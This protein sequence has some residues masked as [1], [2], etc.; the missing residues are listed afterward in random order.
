[1]KPLTPKPQYSLAELTQD[2]GVT[3]AGD[4][5]RLI[6]GVATIQD[7]QPGDIAFLMN[8]LY[9]KHLQKT[10]ASAV[11]LTESDAVDCP[12]TAV[13]SRDPYYTYAKIAA[14]F[15]YH[16]KQPVGIHPT[17]IIGEGCEIDPSVAIGAYT[18]IAD[19]VKLAA[20]VV[21]AEHC[22]IGEFSEIGENT[23]L[24]ARVTLY[25][26]TKIGRDVLIASG[27]VLGSEGFGISKHKGAWHKVP[28]LGRVVIADDVEIGANTTID[29][30]AIGDTVIERGV[31]IDNQVQL[32]H[33]VKIGEYTAIAGCV[34]IAGSTVI[35]KNCLIGGAVGIGGHLVIA[36]DVMITGM[37]AITRTIRDAGVYSS[38]VGGVVPNQEWRKTTARV[39][40]LEQLMQR[41]KA[42]EFALEELTERKDE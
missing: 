33:N 32:G 19:G 6:T 9:K 34:G 7:A 40:R 20:N 16:P 21:I 13:I 37:S 4:A 30:G 8:P 3:I 35:G 41:V 2:L 38:G 26:R 39:Q 22:T 29:R 15:E 14:F 25:Y 42:L 1:M 23:Q 5:T 31:R 36:D 17:V 10:K 12:A 18:T 24:D 28:Q 11:I 27:V